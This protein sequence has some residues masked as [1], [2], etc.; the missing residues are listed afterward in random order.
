MLIRPL[1]RLPAGPADSC[2]RALHLIDLENLLGG[3]NFTAREAVWARAAYLAT[4][5]DANVSHLVLATS[6]HAALAAWFAWPGS[7]RRLVQS[8][9]SGADLAL[10]E[11]I[12]DEGVARRYERIVIGSGDG[13]F[14]FPA[15]QLQAAGCPV[16][17]VTRRD[18]LSRELRLAVRDIRFLKS[19]PHA[20]TQARRAA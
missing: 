8:G 11:L 7:A 1:H 5:P 3:R 15:A 13:I 9:P 4:A 19:A 18:C 14:A 17:V 12:S 20:A 16:T 2:D 6:H 10:L